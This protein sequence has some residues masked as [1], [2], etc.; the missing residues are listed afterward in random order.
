MENRYI[1]TEDQFESIEFLKR[2]FEI[3][4]DRIKDLCNSEKS[5]IEYGFELGQIHSHLR[6][7]FKE[8]L[9]L[10]PV[11]ESQKIIE[12]APEK[13]DPEQIAFKFVKSALSAVDTLVSDDYKNGF[14]EGVEKYIIH[15]NKID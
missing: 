13:F 4:A 11:I 12:K 14:K 15:K 9:V 2:M 3:D 7:C 6:E 1:I 5:D 10:L 8:L